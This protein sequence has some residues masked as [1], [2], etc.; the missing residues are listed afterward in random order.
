M[1]RAGGGER[2]AP[3][4]GRVII[5]AFGQTQ[6]V[7]FTLTGPRTQV[8]RVDVRWQPELVP[9][10]DR[11]GFAQP[12]SSGGSF[13]RAAAANALARVSVAHCAVS[14]QVGSG[15]VTVTFSPTGRVSD[16]VVDDPA[17]SGTPGGRCVQTSFFNAV[18][19]AFAGAPVRV[20]KSFNVSAPIA[21]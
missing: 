4:S 8:A 15:H 11:S 7:P 18:A 10:D 1:V 16:V 2:D 17:F 13:D 14:G 20:G 3:V 12:P 9:I 19:P 6:T 21:R 5:R